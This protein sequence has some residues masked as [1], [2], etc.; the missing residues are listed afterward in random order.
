MS[1]PFRTELVAESTIF[2]TQKAVWK[3]RLRGKSVL[4]ENIRTL[5]FT[6]SESL[7]LLCVGIFNQSSER[8]ASGTVL[9]LSTTKL[10]W[11]NLHFS[12][13]CLVRMYCII[14]EDHKS[15]WVIPCPLQYTIYNAH[16]KIL[17][18]YLHSKKYRM[19][20]TW[21]REVSLHEDLKN[22]LHSKNSA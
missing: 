22:Q 7:Q 2:R 15:M 20:P 12:S 5:A 8:Q 21:N 19:R 9:R 16:H 11:C 14:I 3:E 18:L 17:F 1:F 13:V 4:E 6:P 10:Y